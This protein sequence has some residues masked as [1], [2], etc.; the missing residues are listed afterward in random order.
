MGQE[1][2]NTSKN[3]FTQFATRVGMVLVETFTV[4]AAIAEESPHK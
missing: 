4:Q 1:P 3:A 2:E